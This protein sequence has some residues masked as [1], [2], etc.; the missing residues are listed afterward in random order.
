MTSTLAPLVHRFGNGLTVLIQ[1]DH[2]YPV[3]S[4]QYWVGTGSMNEG[5]LMG[6]GIS[7]F[8]EHLV[9]KG[10]ENYSAQELANI[11]Q[12]RGG[13][14]N[15]YTSTNRTVYY[16]D[17]P[18]ESWQTFLE[19][20]TE[21]VFLPSF[22]ADEIEREMEVVRR[23]MAMYDDEPDSVGYQLLMQTLYK[24]H[25]RRW[26]VL[27]LPHSFSQLTREDVLRYHAERYVPNNVTL[28]IAGAVNSQEVL[29]RLESLVKNLRPQPLMS[30]N[31]P[32]EPKQYGKR[33]AR[34][35]M[36]LPC[37]KLA[38]AWRLP[39]ISHD[40]S[41]A[42]S[43]L[44]SIL[45]GGRSA[46]L[47]EKFHDELGLVYSIDVSVLQS[48]KDEGA[49]VIFADVEREQRDEV[50]DLILQEIKNL[51][52]ADFSADL[53]RVCKQTKMSRLRRRS[54]VSGLASDMGADW[55]NWRNLERAQEWQEAIEQVTV[56]D[57]HRVCETWLASSVITEVSLDPIGSNESQEELQTTTQGIQTYY[58][59]LSNGLPVVICQDKRVPL[60]YLSMV[61]KAGCPTETEE[62]AGVTD[63][64]SECLLK[65]TKT[66]TASEIAREIEDLGG[67]ITSSTGNNSISIACRVAAED[68]AVG[69]EL[70][71]DVVQ[72]PTFPEEAFAKEQASFISAV[73]EELED[74]CALAFRCVR[75]AAYGNVSYGNSPAGTPESLSHLSVDDVK[76]QFE[77]IVCASNGVLSIAGDVEPDEI[78]ETLE[79]HL[80][81][82]KVGESPEFVP[83]PIQQSAEITK[84][85]DKQQAVYVLCLPGI[86]VD[87]P[88][89]AELYLFHGWCSD[90]AGPIFTA[91]REESG[92][93]YYASSSVF[94]GV[95]AGNIYFYFGTSS[96][97]LSEAI[98]KLEQTL[99]R[100]YEH[101]M[102]AAELERCRAATLSARL[103]SM[104]SNAHI[105]QMQA[106]DVLFGLPENNIH[107]QTELIKQVS[108]EQMN[109]FI[110]QVLN[111][112][113]PRTIAVVKPSEQ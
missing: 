93:A 41:V 61:F 25:P 14:W 53:K 80:G 79:R 50:R 46:R 38:L 31:F 4:L 24:K 78:W 97:Q 64:M 99:N 57:L 66:R 104:Q 39:V 77:R 48:E 20:L 76:A 111:P 74:P 85:L 67:M 18:S 105:C 37:S 91:I 94:V 87:S 36:S 58:R 113:N 100:I 109:L 86:Q 16:I 28:V 90:M 60:A 6:S 45:G 2:A 54:S 89:L 29:T 112:A 69:V 101:G 3:V 98:E 43:L 73:E 13:H 108:L 22:P 5:H 63:L 52:T 55:F 95:D 23:E 88:A 15:A 51:V 33:V 34:K 65:S 40:D 8:L 42:I 21:L 62:I 72:N 59:S 81:T 75:K 35:E 19:L 17:G 7:H 1:E 107:R 44:S 56:A 92:L 71:A 70:L 96:A 82:L 12:E 10:T 84:Y 83:T 49:F 27:G 32:A 9:F 30:G 47:Y 11:V 102:T 68:L 103:L 110:K 26:P 106:L